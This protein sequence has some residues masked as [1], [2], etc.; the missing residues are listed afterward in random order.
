MEVFSLE[1]KDILLPYN[2]WWNNLDKAFD[3]LPQF[4][5]PI[6]TKIYREL[7]EIPQIIS[8]TGPRR[9]GKSTLIRQII[10][11]LINQENVKPQEVIYYSMDDPALFLS[12]VFH[13]KLFESIMDFARKNGT[14]KQWIY[15]FLD[16][17]QRFERW[18]LFLKKYYDLHYPVRFVV[19]G[20]ASSPIFK[21]SRESLLGRIK[22]FHL[23]PFSFRE[24]VLFQNRDTPTVVK[25]INKIYENGKAVMG[26]L[27]ERPA[28]AELKNV[29]I[30]KIP[31]SLRKNIDEYFERFLIEGGFPEVWSLP[32]WETKQS[33]LFDN[34]VEK[35]ISED[36]VPA[37]ELR[38]PELLKTFF[39]S[40]LEVPGREISFQQLSKDL[41]INRATIEKYFP[42][43]EMTDLVRHVEKFSKNAVKVRRGNI[44]VYL[45]DLA[46][47]NAILRIQSIGSITQEQMG[48]YI[49]N[50]VFNALEKWEG[51]I[52][53]NY[54]REK[55]KEIDFVVHIGARKYIPIES[56]YKGSIGGRELRNIEKFRSQFKG[57]PGI[58]VTKHWED[59]GNRNNLFYMPIQHFLL[60]FD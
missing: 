56:K 20:F 4:R 58:V 11:N 10:R 34:Q 27:A 26:M 39:I 32:D 47:R 14:E 44:K 24:F 5:R 41:G 15:V 1:Y 12:E 3:R 55:D 52:N 25:K 37:V 17:I 36:L 50:L 29:T 28:Y 49:E 59:F 33:Y 43:L 54:Y 51:T 45:V 8:I 38:K 6:F 18:E 46:L 53:V 19:S 30:P 60:L 13:D 31:V 9:V 35:V 2:P 22:D 7:K 23:L 48:F 40:L 16:E 42:L 57:P 21:K